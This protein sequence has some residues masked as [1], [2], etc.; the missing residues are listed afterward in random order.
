MLIDSIQ[1]INLVSDSDLE[2]GRDLDSCTSKVQ[3]ARP[4]KLNGY[5]VALIDTPGF[6]D[7]SS[8]SQTEILGQIIEFLK[9]R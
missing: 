6:D 1:F 9:T 5:T 4:F 3:L 7:T 2:V 8:S